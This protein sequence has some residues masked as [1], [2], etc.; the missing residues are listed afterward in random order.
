MPCLAFAVVFITFAFFQP[1]VPPLERAAAAATHAIKVC[2]SR[3]KACATCGLLGTPA[4]PAK[5][6]AA[7]GGAPHAHD[8]AQAAPPGASASA[9]A[10]VA[11]AQ[12]H[13]VGA[14][15]PPAAHA[16]TAERRDD[17]GAAPPGAAGVAAAEA[18]KGAEE[19]LEDETGAA[20]DLLDAMEEA[21]DWFA[22]MAKP[23]ISFYQARV[24][25]GRR[26]GCAQ[27]GAREKRA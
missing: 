15:Q 25:E 14:A 8:G 23:L 17:V 9:A 11:A 24:C 4:A 7:S 19:E 26:P 1:V 2:F 10:A 20:M 3:T 6:K 5:D 12:P 18:V 16:H 21:M 27:P 13:H 22:K